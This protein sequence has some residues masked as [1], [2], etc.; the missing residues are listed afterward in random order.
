[1]KVFYLSNHGFGHMIRSIPF[2]ERLSDKDKV[3]VACGANQIDFLKRYFEKKSS[4]FI[5]QEIKTDVGFINYKNGIRVNRN[6]TQ[7]ALYEFMLNLP[8]MVK[9]EVEQLKNFSFSEIYVDISPLGILVG[10]QLKKKVIVLTNFTWYKQY[11]HLKLDQTIIDFYYQLDQQIDELWLYPLSFP[12]EYLHCIKRKVEFMPRP[13]DTKKVNALRTKY[14]HIVSIMSGMSSNMVVQVTNFN[15][16]IVT[17]NKVRV[18]YN[19]PIAILGNECLDSQNYIAASD[20][21]VTK[22]GFTTVS[23][24]IYNKVKMLLIER[25]SAYEDSY[26]ISEVKKQQL[27]ESIKQSELKNLKLG[28]YL[29][30]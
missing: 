30:D 6:K 9:E 17:T 22:S 27:G 1:M 5:F 14:Q 28:Q 2:I 8:Q 4:R 11:L 20:L 21:V 7:Q 16:L 13:I 3:Y 10:K 18:K 25:P 15:G 12:F 23:E 19:G 29:D 26:I 24:C